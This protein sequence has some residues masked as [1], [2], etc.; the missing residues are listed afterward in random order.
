MKT[1]RVMRPFFAY[2]PVACERLFE[3]AAKQGFRL[4]RIKRLGRFYFEYDEKLHSGK[5]YCFYNI[6]GLFCHR[7]LEIIDCEV[8]RAFNV[9]EAVSIG[10][11]VKAYELSK[12][13]IKDTLYLNRI[14]RERG[15][16]RFCEDEYLDS[17]RKD[18]N[19]LLASNR[20]SLSIL[21]SIFAIPFTISGFVVAHWIL[22][23]A[24]LA[25]IP[26]VSAFVTYLKLKKHT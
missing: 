23:F 7:S 21:F 8:R 24:A 19:R 12:N 2:D 16:E 11:P 26:T 17:L 13:T 5:Y 14:A 25:L 4:V 20:R 18:K 15:L 22:F 10:T 3:A 1:Y 6:S 9:T